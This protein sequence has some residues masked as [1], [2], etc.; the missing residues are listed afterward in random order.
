M[1]ERGYPIQVEQTGG[2][3]Y[4]ELDTVKEILQEVNKIARSETNREI[5]I[6]L[7]SFA[8]GVII[9]WLLA[10]LKSNE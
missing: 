6:A 5:I 3:T 9:G 4:S 8:L 10:H 7:L 1:V 2:Q